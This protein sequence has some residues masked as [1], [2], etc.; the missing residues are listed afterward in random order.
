MDPAG[1]GA[2]I[3]ISVMLSICISTKMYD[4][5]KLKEKDIQPILIHF[6]LK[7]IKSN[8]IVRQQSKM[9]MILPK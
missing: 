9:N 7:K 4:S 5:C 2:L 8:F 1:I 6:P 3:G